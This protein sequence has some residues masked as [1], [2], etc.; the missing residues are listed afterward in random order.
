MRGY[1]EACKR[2]Q[3]GMP[4]EY[5]VDVCPDCECDLTP[6]IQVESEW[7]EPE[8]YDYDATDKWR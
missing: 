2:E 3:I 8:D 5:G 4:D 1:C 6:G 7:D